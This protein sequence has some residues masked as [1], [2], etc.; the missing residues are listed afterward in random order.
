ME[1]GVFGRLDGLYDHIVEVEKTVLEP[2]DDKLA[3]DDRLVPL[4]DRHVSEWMI[5][6]I[7]E[8]LLTIDSNVSFNQLSMLLLHAL[9][10]KIV[11]TCWIAKG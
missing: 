7:R 3:K 6:R 8:L 2:A 9:G 1:H 10:Q 5:E 4:H 11:Y